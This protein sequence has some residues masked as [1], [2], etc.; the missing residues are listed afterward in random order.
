[1]WFEVF[2]SKR[3]VLNAKSWFS[4]FFLAWYKK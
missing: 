4:F 3:Q 2:F 1:M